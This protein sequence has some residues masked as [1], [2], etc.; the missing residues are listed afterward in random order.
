MSAL[1]VPLRTLLDRRFFHGLIS[2]PRTD[3][4]NGEQAFDEED[5]LFRHAELSIL[6]MK[7]R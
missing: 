7:V 5:W 2:K 4:I 6:T 1:E 3:I